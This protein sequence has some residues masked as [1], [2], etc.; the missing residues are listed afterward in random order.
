LRFG[1]DEKTLAL[2]VTITAI[3]GNDVAASVC[4]MYNNTHRGYFIIEEVPLTS[5]ESRRRLI[6][7][8]LKNEKIHSQEELQQRLKQEGKDVTQATLSRD[9]KFL[10]IARIPDRREGYVY[11]IKE[12]VETTPE[13]YLHDDIARGIVDIQFSGNLAVIHTKLGHG[14]SVAF[15]I[16]RLEIP[17]VLGTIGGEDTLLV[18]F[19][20]D[21][22]KTSFIKRLTGE[23]T[24]PEN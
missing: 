4:S 12:E 11:T 13:P 20:K 16:D 1:Q 14:H 5:Q 21:A 3:A 2:P 8:I 7:N 9:L 24:L 10:G 23:D 19:G 18:I 22:D 6:V 17:E 15:A